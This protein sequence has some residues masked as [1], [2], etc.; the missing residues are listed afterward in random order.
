MLDLPRG[1]PMD[2]STQEFAARPALIRRAIDQHQVWIEQSLGIPL[3]EGVILNCDLS[4]TNAA[5]PQL[6]GKIDSRGSSEK[7]TRLF[8]EDVE[9]IEFPPSSA[10]LLQVDYVSDLNSRLESRLFL[11]C[12]RTYLQKGG[13]SSCNTP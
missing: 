3:A 13:L 10:P 2:M 12:R 5:I 6:L 7:I 4:L 9:S 1:T 11:I 8:M